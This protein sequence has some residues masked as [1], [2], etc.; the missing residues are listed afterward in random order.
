MSPFSPDS[1]SR[2]HPK[3]LAFLPTL[4]PSHILNDPT[5]VVSSNSI[6]LFFQLIHV[7]TWALLL[8]YLELSSHQLTPSPLFIFAS[9]NIAVL[10]PPT[11][12][13]HLRF[14]Y[15]P[16]RQPLFNNLT[17]VTLPISP[18]SLSPILRARCRNK[19]INYWLCYSI[20]KNF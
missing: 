15:T 5:P 9:I 1:A 19:P 14:I 18:Q 2:R 12:P 7:M 20:N 8:N 17:P 4:P 11:F 3:S 13:I 16:S 6:I 10:S